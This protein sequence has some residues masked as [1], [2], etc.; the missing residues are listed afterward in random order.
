MNMVDLR[1]TYK[2]LIKKPQG[3]EKGDLGIDGR[4]I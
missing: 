4:I 3:D 2:I 1:N